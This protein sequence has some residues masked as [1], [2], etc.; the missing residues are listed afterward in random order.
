MPPPFRRSIWAT[1]THYS[2]DTEIVSPDRAADLV[3]LRQVEAAKKRTPPTPASALV[4]VASAFRDLLS[5]DEPDHPE[6][7]KTA[8]CLARTQYGLGIRTAIAMLAVLSNGDFPPIDEQTSRGLEAMGIITAGQRT[9]LLGNS[10]ERFCEVYL[11]P[12]LR[13]WRI[14]RQELRKPK[15]IDESWANASDPTQ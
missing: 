6:H 14:A 5:K 10:I 12:V 8:L 13:Q 4:C 3:L 15:D 9:A 1:N 2:A 11:G 7:F